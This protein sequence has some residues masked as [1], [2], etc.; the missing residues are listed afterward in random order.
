MSDQWAAFERLLAAL[1]RLEILYAVG[2]SVVSSVHGIPRAT[3]DVDLVVDLPDSK[4][5]PLVEDLKAE[6]FAEADA[7]TRRR[8]RGP[9]V[10][11]DSLQEHVQVR[12]VSASR[13]PLLSDGI[14]S[15]IRSRLFR[16]RE[17]I[18][19]ILG[20][21]RRGRRS[22]ETRL[23][24]SGWG[25]FDAAVERLARDRTIAKPRI[26]LGVFAALGGLP[27]SQ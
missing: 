20:R 16:R 3:V 19:A 23:V 7:V 17:Q 11:L 10:Q 4:I 13:Q 18:A 9:A 24:S 1:D 26:G 27:A 21:H 5:L 8:A 6:F 25:G 14:R 2:G 22:Y 15:S 12:S